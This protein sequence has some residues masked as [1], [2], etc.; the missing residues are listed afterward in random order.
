VYQF[1]SQIITKVFTSLLRYADKE[2]VERFISMYEKSETP[3]EK[4]RL[5]ILLSE[6]V[7]DDLIDYVLNFSLSVNFNSTRFLR[8]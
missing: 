3:E 7:D 6:V 1:R 2:L 8:Y 4:E 5:A